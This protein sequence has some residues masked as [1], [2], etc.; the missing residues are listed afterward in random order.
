MNSRLSIV[1]ASL[2]LAAA[3]CGTS[4][5]TGD[6]GTAGTS[7]SAGAG[8]GGTAGSTGTAGAT[9]TNQSVT[10]RNKNPS[11]DGAFVQPTLTKA[12][13]A[14]M[15]MTSGFNATFTG[16]TY[17][18]PLYFE[19][20]PGGKGIFIAVTTGNDVFALDETT[21]AIV[22]MR[23]IGSSPQD[24]AAGQR[25]Q[26]PHRSPHACREPACRRRA[27]ADAVRRGRDRGGDDLAARGPRAVARRR[28]GEARLAGRRVDGARVGRDDVH[29]AAGKSA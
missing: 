20:G 23:N 1:V 19:N 17:A 8:G 11:R 4:S 18:S 5:S 15:T 22:W 12:A 6:G 26:V 27:V 16:T 13:A 2:S 14:T 21:G 3:A 10:E 7:G 24:R 9:A 25:R 28:H 29:A